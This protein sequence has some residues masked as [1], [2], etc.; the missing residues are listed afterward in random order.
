MKKLS[1]DKIILNS[2]DY[3]SW[4]TYPTG[5]K[6]GFINVF[7]V[8]TAEG[9]AFSDELYTILTANGSAR[10]TITVKAAS[11]WP[12]NIS[13]DGAGSSASN[14]LTINLGDGSANVQVPYTI[15]FLNGASDRSYIEV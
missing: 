10:F 3:L 1:K 12:L 5:N 6:D 2:V 7:N 11:S 9:Y 15:K 8:K 4:G 14:P 13:I